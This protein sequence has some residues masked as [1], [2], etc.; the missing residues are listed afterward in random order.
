MWST[1]EPEMGHG[2][3]RSSQGEPEARR[4]PSSSPQMPRPIQDTPGGTPA[5]P[6]ATR[7]RLQQGGG[8]H[9]FLSSGEYYAAGAA[10]DFASKAGT[11]LDAKYARAQATIGQ[12]LKDWFEQAKRI[13]GPPWEAHR[14][15]VVG[16]LGAHGTH[17]IVGRDF[18]LPASPEFTVGWIGEVH[19]TRGAENRAR[20]L[21]LLRE[22]EVRRRRLLSGIVRQ[23]S[24]APRRPSSDVEVSAYAIVDRRLFL[25]RRDE[26]MN[27]GRTL[28]RI[29]GARTR[30]YQAAA[31][32]LR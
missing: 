30:M 13:G 11:T 8:G 2:P 16:V 18:D 12:A 32:L 1:G 17:A 28:A 24:Q 10:P 19:R 15:Q 3:P 9:P 20:A 5:T 23:I 6:V 31:E 4:R 27:L 25:L 7:L 14:F 21:E 22:F 26:V 29:E